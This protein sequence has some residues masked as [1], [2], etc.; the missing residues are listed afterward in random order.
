MWLFDNINSI[1][2]RVYIQELP[3]LQGPQEFQDDGVIVPATPAMANEDIPDSMQ[4]VPPPP[5]DCPP[6]DLD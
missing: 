5:P 2:F 1:I 3:E 6:P 4:S